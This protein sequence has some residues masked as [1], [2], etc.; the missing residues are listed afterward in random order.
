MGA[1]LPP[2]NTAA[3][4]LMLFRED[5]GVAP[6][7]HPF[8]GGENAALI[9]RTMH[10]AEAMGYLTPTGGRE[11]HGRIDVLDLGSNVIQEFE[12]P[13]R[14]A[15]DWWQRRLGVRGEATA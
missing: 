8:T 15:Y 12:V 7:E 4:A 5:P 9:Q 6:I 14:F 2:L 13:N 11:P 1:G 3:A 10:Y